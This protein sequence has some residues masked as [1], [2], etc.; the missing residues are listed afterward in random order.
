MMF[1]TQ[2]PCERLAHA[3]WYIRRGV[4]SVLYEKLVFGICINKSAWTFLE[5]TYTKRV[6]CVVLLLSPVD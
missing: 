2:D 5:S 1:G 3:R 4:C 6:V